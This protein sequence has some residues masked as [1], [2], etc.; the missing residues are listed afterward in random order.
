MIRVPRPE[1]PE[2]RAI[3]I[4][5]NIYSNSCDSCTY[6]DPTETINALALQAQIMKG[7]KLIRHKLAA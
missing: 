5:R 4:A 7:G 1:R 3:D 6:L 2:R